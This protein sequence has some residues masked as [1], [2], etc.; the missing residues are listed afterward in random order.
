[1]GGGGNKS[2]G[3]VRATKDTM[4]KRKGRLGVKRKGKFES[5][6]ASES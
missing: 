6:R 5:K 1:M 4:R 3:D 2:Q